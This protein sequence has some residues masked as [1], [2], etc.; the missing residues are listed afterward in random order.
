MSNRLMRPFLLLI[1]Q[2]RLLV[3]LAHLLRVGG[4][5]AREQHFAEEGMKAIPAPLLVK[6]NQKKVGALQHFQHLL[7]GLL[8]GQRLTEVCIHALKH[9]RLEQEALLGL[10]Q[11][12]KNLLLYI[13]EKK[14]M[15]ACKCLERGCS[16]LVSLQGESR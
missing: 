4:L 13:I 1:P 12:I 8:P 5:Q 16:S 3:Q 11:G 2:C 6:G 10:R 9:R 14:A 7:T 15:T